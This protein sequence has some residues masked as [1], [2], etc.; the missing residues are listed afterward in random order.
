VPVLGRLREWRESRMLS[1]RMLASRAK[2]SPAT[3]VRA[4]KGEPVQFQTAQD[5]A[6]A[7]DIEPAE[8]VAA[9]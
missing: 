7:L 3:V 2:V 8:L 1:Q 4:E 5:I 6:Q 9:G